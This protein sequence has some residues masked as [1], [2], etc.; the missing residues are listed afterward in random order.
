MEGGGGCIVLVLLCSTECPF[1]F[2]NQ[3]TEDERAVC[4]ALIVYLDKI[5][6]KCQVTDLKILGRLGTNIF[7]IIFFLEK[8]KCYAF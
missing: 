4:F 3:L 7:L 6:I 2:C 1:Y 5:K 8:I